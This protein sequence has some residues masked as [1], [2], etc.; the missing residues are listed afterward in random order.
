MSPQ[1]C[2]TPF[3]YRGNFSGAVQSACWPN[4]PQAKTVRI[5]LKLPLEC[6][7]ANVTSPEESVNESFSFAFNGGRDTEVSADLILCSDSD[8]GEDE[9]SF[10]V[11]LGQ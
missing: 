5:V 9:R 6:F 7:N 3:G 1:V 2:Y 11:V 10:R 8:A 4:T